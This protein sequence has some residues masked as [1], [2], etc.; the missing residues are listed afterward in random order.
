MQAIYM[1]I[2]TGSVGE[3][4]SWYYELEDGT[5]VNAV[6]LKEVEE[7]EEWKVWID[8]EEDQAQI[9][10]MPV[11]PSVNIVEEA[12]KVLGVDVCAEINVARG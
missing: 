10:F 9:F 2:F 12:A 3:Y 6:D 7:V 5:E 1:N 11:W 4:N 8:G